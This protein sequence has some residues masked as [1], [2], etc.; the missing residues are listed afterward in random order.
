[1]LLNCVCDGSIK[2]QCNISGSLCNDCSEMKLG[3]LE[4]PNRL[5]AYGEGEN[6]KN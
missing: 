1:M 4:M 5:Q 6:N 2:R 3:C